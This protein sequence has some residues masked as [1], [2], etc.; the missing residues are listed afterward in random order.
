MPYFYVLGMLKYDSLVGQLTTFSH[1][2]VCACKCWLC[3]SFVRAGVC[4]NV[5]TCTCVCQF[6]CLHVCLCVYVCICVSLCNVCL[7]LFCASV[8]LCLCVTYFVQQGSQQGDK[9]Q[10][11]LFH[12]RG[13]STP[14]TRKPILTNSS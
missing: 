9:V 14:H 5:Y 10:V 1:T 12:S 6:E 2:C 3:L 8:C 11:T 13:S 4:A 7:Q